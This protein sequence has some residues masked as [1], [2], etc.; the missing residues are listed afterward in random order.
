MSEEK[1]E[2]EVAIEQLNEELKRNVSD[3]K[4]VAQEYLKY[5]EETDDL[6]NDPASAE[7]NPFLQI[8]NDEPV[9]EKK[10]WCF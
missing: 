1:K 7:S 2:Y 8:K 3:G 4:E 5:I 9:K 10:C 6:L